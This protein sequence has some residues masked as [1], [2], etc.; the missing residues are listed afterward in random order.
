M[1][2]S[3]VSNTNMSVQQY[4]NGSRMQMR[5]QDGSGNG[6]GKQNKMNCCS[7]DPAVGSLFDMKV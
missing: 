4:Q 2:I 1:A 5:K 6:Q 3:S 7:L